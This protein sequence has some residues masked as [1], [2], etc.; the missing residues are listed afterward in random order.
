MMTK[1]EFQQI[2]DDVG[3][4]EVAARLQAVAWWDWDIARIT[5]CLPAISGGDVVA[6][7]AEAAG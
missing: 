4:P 7:E 2:C 1:E 6:L 3:G 5:R